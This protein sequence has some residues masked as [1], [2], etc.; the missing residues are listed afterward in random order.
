MRV[1]WSDAAED[2]LVSILLYVAADDKAAAFRLVDKLEVA[3]NSLVDFPKRGRQGRTPGTRELAV[4]ST[5]YIL[6]Y[7]ITGD[8]VEIFHVL[9]GARDWPSHSEKGTS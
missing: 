5:K 1:I 7:E 2:D 6:I 9:H 8:R 4:S 3:G